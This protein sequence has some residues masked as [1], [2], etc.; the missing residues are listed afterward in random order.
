VFDGLAAP[1]ESLARENPNTL[2]QLPGHPPTVLLTPGESTT[3]HSV[4]RLLGLEGFEVE[5]VP[6]VPIARVFERLEAM[7]AQK[8]PALALLIH[9]G[10]LL[11]GSFGCERVMDI[12]WEWSHRYDASLPLGMNVVARRLPLEARARLSSLFVASCKWAQDHLPEFLDEAARASSPF[13]TPLSRGELTEYLGLYA[14]DTTQSVSERDARA[15]ADLLERARR[16]GLL[17]SAQPIPC[18]WI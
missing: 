17:T 12:G 2:V 4:A 1:L 6:I 9:E 15:F 7:E 13:H 8:R 18:D 11:Y 14:N 16:A 10:R 5:T 3:A